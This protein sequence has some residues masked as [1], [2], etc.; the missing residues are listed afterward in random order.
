MDL[1]VEGYRLDLEDDSIVRAT[2]IKPV[3]ITSSRNLSRHQCLFLYERENSLSDNLQI[4][5]DAIRSNSIEDFIIIEQSTKKNIP[6][7]YAF[8]AVFQI[9]T[10]QQYIELLRLHNPEQLVELTDYKA[11][12]ENEYEEYFDYLEDSALAEVI[13]NVPHDTFEISYPEKLYNATIS[14]WTT[15]KIYRFGFLKRTND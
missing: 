3:E 5:A 1:Y 8:V 7:P 10:E 6:Y 13:K 11:N 9:C 14:G 15:N 12:P 2:R 4:V